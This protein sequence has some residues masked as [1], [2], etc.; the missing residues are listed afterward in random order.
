M[1]YRSRVFFSGQAEVRDLESLAARSIQAPPGSSA[2][3]FGT[4]GLF[5]GY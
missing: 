3:A 1:K 5:Y 4:C 2:T